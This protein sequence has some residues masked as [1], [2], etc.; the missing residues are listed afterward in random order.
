MPEGWSEVL[1]KVDIIPHGVNLK[2]FFPIETKL[3][4]FT[5]F[6]DGGWKDSWLDRKGISY[7]VK[8]Y[9]DEFTSDDNV[10]LVVKINMTYG[11][12]PTTFQEIVTSNPKPPVL[13]IVTDVLSTE[14]LNKLYNKCDVFVI[15][16]MA[17]GFHLGGI[18][19]MACGKPVLYTDFGGHTDYCDDINGWKLK[20][21]EMF[22]VKHDLSY[23]G[24]RWKKPKIEEIRQQLRYIYEH[25]DTIPNKIQI[26]YKTA[27]EFT[28]N[29]SGA[30][31]KEILKN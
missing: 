31:V 26:A 29:H 1:A 6:T 24:I 9:L 28:W 3:D 10:E 11:F 14:D 5:F 20:E 21:G 27:T 18:Q 30:K 2:Q 13:K 17:E 16:S 23:E 15:S 7:L 19:A 4:R 8:A 12:K 25:E 22:E